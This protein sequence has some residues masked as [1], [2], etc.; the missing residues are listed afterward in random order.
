M[1]NWSVSHKICMNCGRLLSGHRDK[2]GLLKMECPKCGLRMVS[3]Q[4]GRRRENIDVYSPHN[5]EID[6]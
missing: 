1:E 4:M 6:G 3:K 2:N 5:T